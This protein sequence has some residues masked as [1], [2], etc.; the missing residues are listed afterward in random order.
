MPSHDSPFPGHCGLFGD[1]VALRDRTASQSVRYP[2]LGD[3]LSR[4][5]T[6]VEVEKPS[7]LATWA[8][9]TFEHA[10]I[11]LAALAGGCV[12]AP[13]GF[14]LPR[15]EARRRAI[16]AGAGLL[17]DGAEFEPL[18]PPA[19]SVSPLGAGTL[20]FTSG[21]SGPARMVRHPL[22]AHLAN[23][24]GAAERIPLEPG[25]GWLLSLP[26]HHVSGFSILVRCLT[27]GAT[28]VFPDANLPLEKQI[29]DSAVTHLSVVAVQ[30][31]HLL[32]VGA[33]LK[34]LRA[35]LLGGG[36]IDPTLVR[37]ALQAGAPLFV[38]YGM[39]ETASQ[40]TTTEQLLSAPAGIHA[41][42]TLPGREIRFS[43]Q[44][45]IE[46]RG[47]V[48][49]AGISTHPEGWYPTG[50]AGSFDAEGNL[51]IHGRRDRMIISGGENIH[52][53]TLEQILGTCA[54]VRRAV[55]VGVPDRDYGQRPVAF[56][57]GQVD[58]QSLRNCLATQVER[59]AIPDRFLHWPA[60]VDPDSAKL[61][62]RRM[63]RL[64]LEHPPVP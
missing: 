51:L 54:G 40:I 57:C 34:R 58:A 50:D 9:P 26:L 14:R 41:G 32:K 12:V 28:V 38:T 5:W 63:E 44:G 62:F 8:R 15:T 20:L 27:A 7:T 61:D 11:L 19:S 39:T 21:S 1:A 45:E 49:A 53:E 37:D 10:S 6:R 30:L 33:P 56:V 16:E 55:V 35:V 59:F 52:P 31:R 46:V 64:A 3:F 42:K 2:E 36:P 23:A 47:P 43:P 24:A 48:L 29:E 4:A 22:A 17:F 13:L 25:C 18:P 60:D